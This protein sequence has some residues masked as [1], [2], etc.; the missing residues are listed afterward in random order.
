[1][2]SPPIT[3]H[4]FTESKNDG[5]SL[6]LLPATPDR[7]LQTID[8]D[9]FFGHISFTDFCSGFKGSLQLELL[10]SGKSVH[11]TRIKTDHLISTDQGLVLMRSLPH[12]RLGNIHTDFGHLDFYIVDTT[13]T[14]T[15]SDMKTAIYTQVHECINKM[16]INFA[17][18]FFTKTSAVTSSLTENLF[19]ITGKI[20]NT[21]LCHLL[22]AIKNRLSESDLVVYLEVFGNKAETITTDSTFN[23]LRHKMLA[24]FS[25]SALSNFI[26]DICIS[27]S[28][29]N[30]TV[31][32]ANDTFFEEL[33]IKPTHLPLMSSVVKN[34]YMKTINKKTG[35]LDSV[36][37]RFSCHKLNFYSTFKYSFNFERSEYYI[38]P[39]T[40]SL[41]CTN[42]FGYRVFS[43][44]DKYS[45]LASEFRSIERNVRLQ[46][47][48]T[49]MYRTEVRCRY[50]NIE[51]VL[52]KLRSHVKPENFS[53]CDSNI[54]YNILQKSVNNFLDIIENNGSSASPASLVVSAIA[55]YLMKVV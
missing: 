17:S 34:L 51:S 9:S 40:T 30:N 47:S 27:V 20:Q 22:P 11:E 10:S 48:S 12:A 39:L 53:Y 25:N 18:G 42:I 1:M 2:N 37:K 50:D 49:C 36:G 6:S 52:E 41:L 21:D 45:K 3:P 38:L 43:R 8:L 33:Q 44:K 16:G 55:E 54:F 35:E 26:V 7:F 19:R 31:A 46:G 14:I 29:G 32:L 13:S 24:V 23:G 5:L 28:L 4:S 15:E